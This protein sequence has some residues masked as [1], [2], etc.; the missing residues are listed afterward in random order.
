MGEK[1]EWAIRGNHAFG[2][3][4]G[5][6]CRNDSVKLFVKFKFEMVLLF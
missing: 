1:R 5:N 4:D 2:D 3:D 6:I